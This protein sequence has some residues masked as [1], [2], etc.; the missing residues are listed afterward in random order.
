[1]HKETLAQKHKLRIGPKDFKRNTRA[2]RDHERA[3]SVV[4]VSMLACVI[5]MVTF[6]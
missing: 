6:T 4:F 5:F 2:K 1:M 3:V